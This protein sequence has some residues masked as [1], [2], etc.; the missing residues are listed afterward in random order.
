M[1]S[2]PVSAKIH[3]L[4]LFRE[5]QQVDYVKLITRSVGLN[6]QNFF[7]L[8]FLANSECPEDTKCL[9]NGQCLTHCQ[10]TSDCAEYG[11]HCER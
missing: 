1:G 5:F 11:E 10:K 6:V 4:I 7:I 9:P 2:N 8:T 3:H